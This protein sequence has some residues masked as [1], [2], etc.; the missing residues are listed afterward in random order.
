MK[1]N[2]FMSQFMIDE[3]CGSIRIKRSSQ[4]HK[5][6][7]IQMIRKW[8]MIFILAKIMSCVNAQIK[9]YTKKQAYEIVI[10][11]HHMPV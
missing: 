8:R 11:L 4:K 10:L 9:Q 7:S 1:E 6:I 3:G 5:P 2:E